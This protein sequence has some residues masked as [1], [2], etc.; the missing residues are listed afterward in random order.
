MNRCLIRRL[1]SKGFT[2]VEVIATII[3]VAIISVIFINFMSTAMSKSTRAI[4]DV[5][6]EGNAQAMMEQI[7]ADYA[8]EINKADPSNALDTIK[9]KNYPN[10]PGSAITRQYITFDS[11]GNQVVSLI[12]TRTLRI[13]VLWN[14]P[15]VTNVGGTG[16]MTLLTQSRN[17][18]S[19]PGDPPQPPVAF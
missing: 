12:P 6:A 14:L 2:L 18:P 17:P 13:T 7:V 8:I 19:S 4:E 11:N 3:A 15:D 9:N 10:Y 1:N 16:L 5:E